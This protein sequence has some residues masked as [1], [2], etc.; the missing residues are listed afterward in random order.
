MTKRSERREA[1]Q[2]ILEAF[3]T[4]GAINVSLHGLC[5]TEVFPKAFA[6]QTEFFDQPMSEKT[7][8]C[9]AQS[10]SGYAG[11][12]EEATAGKRDA[13][14]TFT[15][16][17]GFG[18]G[19]RLVEGGVPCHGPVPWPSGEFKDAVSDS[20]EAM[21]RIGDAVLPLIALG[22]GL[23]EDAF[24]LLTEDSWGHMRCVKYCER[25]STNMQGLG[26]HTDYG[27][28]AMI[29]QDN[30]GGLWVRPEEQDFQ[31]SSSSRSRNWRESSA[32]SHEDEGGWLFVPPEPNVVTIFPGDMMEFATRGEIV[33]TLHKVRLSDEERHSMAYFHEPAFGA[34][35]ERPDTGESIHYGTHFTDMFMRC[36]PDK[37]VT[38]RINSHGLRDNLSKTVNPH[39]RFACPQPQRRRCKQPPLCCASSLRRPSS[40]TVESRIHSSRL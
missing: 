39:K 18:L 29:A 32:G 23:Q 22:L 1:G 26:A 3:R 24:D 19:H 30:V 31:D 7:T 35:L 27:L 38:R 20:M 10:Y 40:L 14:E 13:A 34:V 36:Y 28:L 2:A 4:D 12:G 37:L 11:S 15:V 25:A 33:A 21:R 16:T 6:A 9:N 17:P 8:L 5:D